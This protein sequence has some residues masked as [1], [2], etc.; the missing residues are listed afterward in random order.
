MKEIDDIVTSNGN[1]VVLVIHSFGSYIATAYIHYH[2]TK[3]VGIIEFGGI[4]A[5]GYTTI[6]LLGERY[7]FGGGDLSVETLA[8]NKESIHKDYLEW[9]KTADYDMSLAIGKHALIGFY[10][11]LNAEFF[12][13]VFEW[14][15]SYPH[16]LKLITFGRYDSLFEVYLLNEVAY[17]YAYG[18]GSLP[19]S[20]NKK[21]IGKYKAVTGFEATNLQERFVYSFPRAGHSLHLNRKKPL[22]NFMNLYLSLVLSD[23][24]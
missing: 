13:N 11:L 15:R 9:L 4:P 8:K 20:Y 24:P 16:I 2:P 21:M 18:A 1:R 17:H 22:Q 7:I 14:R 10:A 5:T 3:V 12:K 23:Y 6:K 19:E